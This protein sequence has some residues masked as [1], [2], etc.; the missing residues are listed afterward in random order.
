M[1]VHIPAA[2]RKWSGGQD[3]VELPLAA[4]ARVTLAEIFAMLAGEHPGI[5]QRVLDDQ[6]ML[7]RHVNVFVDGEN[8]RFA[9]GLATEVR[10][11]SD[12]IIFPAVS[13]GGW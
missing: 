8:V 11:D 12:I 5:R 13:G 2:L 3:A 1:R 4:D 9:G 10:A 7:R 6:G